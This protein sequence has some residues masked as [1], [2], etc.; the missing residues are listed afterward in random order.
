MQLVKK[1]A[2]NYF[3][4]FIMRFFSSII[5]YPCYAGFGKFIL[6]NDIYQIKYFTVGSFWYYLIYQF[7]MGSIWSFFFYLLFGIS[8]LKVKKTNSIALFFIILLIFEL[9]FSNLREIKNNNFYSC[10]FVMEGVLQTAFNYLI[11]YFI[12]TY[13]YSNFGEKII[14]RP[15][16]LP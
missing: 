1:I 2:C 9:I 16:S 14:L 4:I 7:S 5:A 6:H 3:I 10:D 15:T 12:F 8:N 13:M 11:L